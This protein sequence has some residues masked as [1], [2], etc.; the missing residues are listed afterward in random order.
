MGELPFLEPGFAE[1]LYYRVSDDKAHGRLAVQW[2]LKTATGSDS[3]VR[4]VALVFDWC[5]DLLSASESAA[6]IGRLE[7]APGCKNRVGPLVMSVP[8][9]SPR[10]C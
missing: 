4:Q 8:D 3:D 1:A 2:A 6:L 9:C 5:Q 10:L 7:R